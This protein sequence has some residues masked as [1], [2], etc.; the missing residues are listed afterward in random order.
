MKIIKLTKH[1]NEFIQETVDIVDVEVGSGS[2]A[3]QG[4]KCSMSYVGTLKSDGSKF[5]SA[6]KFSFTIGAGEVI[7]VNVQKNLWKIT[8]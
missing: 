5:D 6:N 4:S 3:G 8:F 1:Q 2:E 7:K